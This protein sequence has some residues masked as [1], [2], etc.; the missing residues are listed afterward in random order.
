MLLEVVHATS[1]RYSSEVTETHM[2]LRLRPT[3]G[4]GQRLRS[5]RLDILPGSSIQHH[6]DGFGNHVDVFHH[7]LPLDRLEVVSTSLVETGVD[8]GDEANEPFQPVDLLLFRPPVVE[9]ARVRRLAQRIGLDD[10]SSPAEVADALERLNLRIAAELVYTP[11][12]TTI[13][14]GVDEVLMHRRGVCQDFAHVF[15]AAARCM[16]LPARYVS[17]Y[18]HDGGRIR[19]DG[20]SHAWAEALIPGQGWAFFDP[21]HPKLP[22]DHYVRIAT[23]RDY[24]DAAPTR[25]VFRGRATSELR[26]GVATT[27]MD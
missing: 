9:T 11:E 7:L 17:G 8:D 15:V 14:T 26:V 6:V 5:Y 18:V 25:G 22:R 4:N 12:S 20:A 3:D 23:G 10:P 21:T 13:S 1:Y 16:G 24:Q 2:A 19:A 27:V